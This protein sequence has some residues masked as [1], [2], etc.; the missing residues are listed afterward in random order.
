FQIIR[1]AQSLYAQLQAAETGQRG[2]ILTQREEYLAPY[3]R[4][5]TSIPG[6]VDMLR[7]LLGG[8][9]VQ[10]D[11][12]QNLDAQIRRKLTE[13][14]STIEM[15]QKQGFEAARQ[16]VLGDVGLTAMEDIRTNLRGLVEKETA[17]STSRLQSSRD[18]E[19][20]ILFIAIGT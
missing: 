18:W 4:A 11:R 14:A 17:I 1:T 5:L 10:L 16:M 9:P 20:R 7:G 8:D 12:L 15:A 3:K 13:L 2:Y 6:T 19:R